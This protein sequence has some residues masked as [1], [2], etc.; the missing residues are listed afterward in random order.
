MVAIVVDDLYPAVGDS[1]ELTIAVI[2]NNGAHAVDVA[3]IAQVSSQPGTDASIDPTVFVTGEDG[4]S[5][6]TLYVG[7]T[8]GTVEVTVNCGDAETGVISIQVGGGGAPASLPD[9]G[10]GDSSLPVGS[11][12]L[13][14]TLLLA[15]SGLLVAAAAAVRLRK[16]Q[17]LEAQPVEVQSVFAEPKLLLPKNVA[18]VPEPFAPRMRKQ[19]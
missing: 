11:V 10:V 18:N 16:D 15:A 17:A 12:G 14:P 3:C 19:S 1:V 13:L 7:T 9:A 6:A 5:N 4:E 8:A 2:E